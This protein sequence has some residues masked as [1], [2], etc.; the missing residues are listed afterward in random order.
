MKPGQANVKMVPIN[1]MVPRSFIT[2]LPAGAT[3]GAGAATAVRGIAFGGDTGVR[4][5]DF[6]SDGGKSWSPATLGRDEGKYSFR[7]WQ[8][9]FTAPAKGDYV[10]MARCTNADGVAQ[11]DQANW[12]PAGYMRNVIEATPVT[13]G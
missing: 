10:L 1:K 5:V 6:S 4:R 13:A 8:T 12:N 2:N 7:R 11:L 9:N 3:I